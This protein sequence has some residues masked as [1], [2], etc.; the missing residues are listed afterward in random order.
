MTFPKIVWVRD[1]TSGRGWSAACIWLQCFKR[2]RRC[3]FRLRYGLFSLRIIRFGF[4]KLKVEHC[5]SKWVLEKKKKS[6]SKRE[7]PSFLNVIISTGTVTSNISLFSFSGL[8]FFFRF[9]FSISFFFSL[10]LLPVMPHASHPQERSP[11]SIAL[12]FLQYVSEVWIMM[13]TACWPTSGVGRSTVGSFTN[14]TSLGLQPL[15]FC[16]LF[17]GS[18]FI[19]W[20]TGDQLHAFSHGRAFL[21]FV[22][23]SFHW[24]PA[25]CPG[26]LQAQKK[27]TDGTASAFR[28][29]LAFLALPWTV[30]AES[31]DSWAREGKWKSFGGSAHRIERCFHSRHGGSFLLRLDKGQLTRAS[32]AHLIV[33]N[34]N[35]IVKDSWCVHWKSE[36]HNRDRWLAFKNRKRDP[37]S[38]QKH[39]RSRFSPAMPR[40]SF[41]DNLWKV[42]YCKLLWI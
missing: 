12:L 39:T 22:P 34:Y 37:R 24:R 17:I 3:F 4:S 5:S 35:G 8:F 13:H 40:T 7:K 32:W 25:H 15:A 9:F 26:D 16:Q 36:E 19:I 27:S 29:R 21:C 30:M 38:N 14:F 6:P 28:K 11:K 20:P 1:G 10:P 33:Q 23:R 41:P 31:T 42:L 2:A 18:G